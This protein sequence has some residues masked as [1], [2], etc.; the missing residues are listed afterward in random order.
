MGWHMEN[1]VQYRVFFFHSKQV[2]L[3]L[4]V[5]VYIKLTMGLDKKNTYI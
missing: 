4:F 3:R 5:T 2:S 1:F